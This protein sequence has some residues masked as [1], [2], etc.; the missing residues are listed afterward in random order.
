MDLASVSAREIGEALDRIGV[1]WSYDNDGDIRVRFRSGDH[2]WTDVVY[3]ELQQDYSIRGEFLNGRAVPQG[4]GMTQWEV[5]LDVEHQPTAIAQKVVTVY[6]TPRHGGVTVQIHAAVSPLN[7][8]RPIHIKVI[9]GSKQV[10]SI[11]D[12]FPGYVGKEERR[13]D[14]SQFWL[15]VGLNGTRVDDADLLFLVKRTFSIGLRMFDG[16]FSGWLYSTEV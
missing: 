3:Y 6:L 7:Q 5:P 8:P 14:S 1:T 12:A 2:P 4:N 13:G 16:P 10:S 11:Q 9:P 15:S